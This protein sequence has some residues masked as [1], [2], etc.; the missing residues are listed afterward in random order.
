MK[1]TPVGISLLLAAAVAV[2]CRAAPII[3]TIAFQQGTAGYS[4]S[5]D[6]KIGP[7][8][9][10]EVDGSTVDT[11]TTSYFIDGGASALNDTGATH[12]LLRFDSIL[13]GGGI[14]AGAKIISAS[15]DV[16]TGST[17]NAQTGG[18]Y[19]LYRL[20][21]PFNSSSSWAT[22]FGGDGL[23]GNVGEILGSF[24]GMA[25]VGNPASARADRAVQNW[26]N[27]G[28][29]HGFGIRSDRSTDGWSPHT[30]GSATVAS[31][32]KLTINYT[33]DP[34]VEIASY[35]DGVNS[36]T[37]SSDL[38]IDSL[39]VNTDG[40]T[41]QEV[42]M[43]GFDEAAASPD[44]AYLVRFD[45]LNLAGYQQIHKAELILVSGFSN[46]AADSPGPFNIHQMLRDWTTSS[47]YAEFDSN[48][49]PALNT[50]VE[51]VAG[52]VLAP[53]AATATGMNDTEVV[54]LDVTSIVENW[55]SGQANYGFYIGT[56]AV[57]EGGTSNG[58]QVFT[59]GAT[60]ASFRPELRII[61]IRVPEPTSAT[62]VIAGGV[63]LTALCQ[64]RRG[65][66]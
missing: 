56:P 38:R 59:T 31:R 28:P 65:R 1:S 10:S 46:G 51:L 57:S 66:K 26:L 13:G 17:S 43:D 45:G 60:D 27:G 42:F 16:V 9:A 64:T 50:S 30:T 44:Q 40:S 6:R 33:L 11:D 25:A 37:S 7:T 61:G 12:G 36:Y 49:N 23:A 24:D 34:L 53:A 20:T 8:A 3:T 55:R 54:H 52:G 29:N 18:A 2:P 22:D 47:T 15:V 19:N 5:F 58:W 62:L 32:P 35:Q 63:L 48:G 14:P 39:G 4:G 41:V 21:T